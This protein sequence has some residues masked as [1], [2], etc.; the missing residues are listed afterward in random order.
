MGS[1]SH[2]TS[3]P[4]SPGFSSFSRKKSRNQGGRIVE[5]E[6][7]SDSHE[8]TTED[9]D[10]LKMCQKRAKGERTES[11]LGFAK[12]EAEVASTLPVGHTWSSQLPQ[13][14]VFLLQVIEIHSHVCCCPSLNNKRKRP[15]QDAAP[16]KEIQ[17]AVSRLA[18]DFICGRESQSSGR[19]VFIF[20]TILSLVLIRASPGAISRS[21]FTHSLI[22]FPFLSLM[23]AK[24]KLSTAA[25]EINRDLKAIIL[26]LSLLL[27]L[28]T[29][30]K[31]P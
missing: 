7:H 22:L 15:P 17:T 6:I 18:D 31:L 9:W 16:Q 19:I 5:S 29:R 14:Y 25:M 26:K 8:V 28:L 2:S 21:T 13:T 10:P 30:A 3:E 23:E 12:A 24:S 1:L 20:S 4:C 11:C 27:T